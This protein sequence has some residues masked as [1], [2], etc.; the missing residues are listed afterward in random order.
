MKPSEIHNIPVLIPNWLV[1]VALASYDYLLHSNNIYYTM[2]RSFL[3][4]SLFNLCGLVLLIYL[5]L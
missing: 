2:S 5:S 1:P 3:I 4:R